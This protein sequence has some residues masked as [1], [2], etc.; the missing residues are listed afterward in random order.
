MGQ[1]LDILWPLATAVTQ[2]KVLG[3][4]LDD[5]AGL[6]IAK[7][8]LAGV[9]YIDILDE[10]NEREYKI[11][12]GSQERNITISNVL[13]IC[14]SALS[15][16]IM[17]V[18]GAVAD[19][20]ESREELTSQAEQVR[21]LQRSLKLGLSSNAEHWFYSKGLADRAICKHL[22]DTVMTRGDEARIGDGFFENN[23]HY[24]EPFLAEY[25]TVFFD[26][27]YSR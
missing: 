22:S 4:L 14:D 15:Y 24:I 27:V 16:N 18:V 13:D 23:K 19:L 25:P 9:S 3:K 11:L 10:A 5:G 12:A 17:L 1:W 26:S 7:Q 6:H 2:S 21:M 8:W 20:M